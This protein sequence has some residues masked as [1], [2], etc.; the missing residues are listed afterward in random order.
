MNCIISTRMK[1]SD[2]VWSVLVTCLECGYSMRVASFVMGTDL[3][4][5]SCKAVLKRTEYLTSENLMKKIDQIKRETEQTLEATA[6]TVIAGFSPSKPFKSYKKTRDRLNR[7]S[8][9]PQKIKEMKKN[10]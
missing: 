9:L 10:K 1:G 4:C 5:L 7:I 3:L 6:Q 8:A 2:G